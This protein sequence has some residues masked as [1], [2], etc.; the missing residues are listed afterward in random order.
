MKDILLAA[1]EDAPT[2]WPD[3]VIYIVLMLV[4]AFMVWC[5]TR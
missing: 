5:F 3:A 1:S 2:S 4:M